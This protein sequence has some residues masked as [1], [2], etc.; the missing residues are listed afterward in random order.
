MNRRIPHPDNPRN[1]QCNNVS[2]TFKM[3]PDCKALDIRFD[4]GTR[5]VLALGEGTGTALIPERGFQFPHPTTMRADPS[6]FKAG[7][8]SFA[9]E[10]HCGGWVTM[11]AADH[12][13]HM[14]RARVEG[15]RR[16][17]ILHGHNIVREITAG[18][19]VAFTTKQPKGA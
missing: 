15:T 5:I 3:P 12:S 14:V 18:D 13:G 1:P 8:E 6:A 11:T 7:S 19:I 17:C 16:T 10:L 2:E 4:A 9:P